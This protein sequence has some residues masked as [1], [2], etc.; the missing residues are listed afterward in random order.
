M[1][2]SCLILF[3]L[4]LLDN[5][6]R[7]GC[8]WNALFLLY[9]NFSSVWKGV[10]SRKKTVD[11]FSRKRV[12]LHGI[13]HQ[14]PILMDECFLFIWGCLSQSRI[15]H[16]YMYWEVTIAGEGL[17]ILSHAR[18]SLPLSSEG[19]LACHTYCGTGYPFIMVISGDPW[20]SHLPP[21]I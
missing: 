16:L 15:F 11:S 3:S 19:S 12:Y 18:H 17:Q 13:N 1:T 9:H 5:F 10:P 7:K 2:C 14:F 21:S 4:N 8:N 6:Y 20:H